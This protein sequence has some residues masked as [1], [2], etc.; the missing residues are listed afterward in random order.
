MM[1]L[2]THLLVDLILSVQMEYVLACPNIREIP[3]LVAGLN[4]SSIMIVLVTKLALEENVSIHV[5]ELV[6]KMLSVML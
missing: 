5:Q 4:V 6:V 2:V 1:T 3:I